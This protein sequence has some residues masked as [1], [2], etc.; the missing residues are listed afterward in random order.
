V[1]NYF[2]ITSDTSLVSDLQAGIIHTLAGFEKNMDTNHLV[3]KTP[4]RYFVDWYSVPNDGGGTATKNDGLHSAVVS[5]HYAFALQNAVDL[6]DVLGDTIMANQYRTRAAEIKQAVY[7]NC[8][9]MDKSIFAERPDKSTYD[10]HTNIMAILTDAIPEVQQ[11]AL[12][13]K[14][15]DQEELL[16]ASYY[17]RYYLFKAVKKVDAQELFHKAQEP[18]EIMIDDNMSTPLERFES[19][20]RPTRSE[21]HPW[22]A[23]PAYFYLTYLA[24]IN[25][26]ERSK[27]ISVKPRFGILNKMEGEMPTTYGDIQFNFERD[28]KTFFMDINLTDGTSGILEYNNRRYELDE[29]TNTLELNR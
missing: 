8:Y 22:S 24:G 4:Y 17:Y 16:Q 15:L 12:L 14:L 11:K 13:I 19:K 1:A 10:Q 20:P 26:N 21:V 27:I 18:W 29:G 23:S 7:K 5:L 28:E 2:R 25:I 3:K 6:M 9:D